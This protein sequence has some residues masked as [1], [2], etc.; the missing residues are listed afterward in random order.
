[1]EKTLLNFELPPSPFAR[2][3]QALEAIDPALRGIRSRAR[4]RK[5]MQIC[6]PGGTVGHATLSEWERKELIADVRR[7]V[8]YQRDIALK[9]G[10][11]RQAVR[12]YQKRYL[13]GENS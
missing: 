10:I 8:L 9:Y 6:P 7:M 1:M 5:V 3:K 13:E 12:G 4:E 2:E 11:T